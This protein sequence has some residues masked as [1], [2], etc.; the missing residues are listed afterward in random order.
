M[1]TDGGTYD[2][3][4][5]DAAIKEANNGITLFDGII[6]RDTFKA[7]KNDVLYWRRLLDRFGD[8][9]KYLFLLDDNES[10]VRQAQNHKIPTALSKLSEPEETIARL[11][12]TYRQVETK[13]RL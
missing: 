9:A 4:D 5:Y 2:A 10:I 13:H 11:T 6:T 12:K 8:D 3:M 1:A 7:S